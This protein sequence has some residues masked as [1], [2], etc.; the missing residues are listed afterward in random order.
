MKKQYIFIFISIILL[1][2]VVGIFL[3]NNIP[4]KKDTP[5]HKNPTKEDINEYIGNEKDMYCESMIYDN[6]DLYFYT[7]VLCEN[8]SISDTGIIDVE[9]GFSMAIRFQ[10]NLE[11]G[12]IEGYET[13]KDGDLYMDSIKE[14]FPKGVYDQ[15][16]PSNDEINKLES[17]AR[18]KFLRLTSDTYNSKLGKLLAEYPE[19]KDWE[20]QESFAGKSYFYTLDTENFYFAFITNGSGVYLADVK[21]YKVDKDNKVSQITDGIIDSMDGGVDPIT[22]NSY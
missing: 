9:E 16:N 6:D 19:Y 7:W 4:I 20:N 12:K 22:C 2:L 8:F 21:C 18:L 17:N 5:V 3:W 13:P 15:F 14:L 11:N 1:T 10:Y